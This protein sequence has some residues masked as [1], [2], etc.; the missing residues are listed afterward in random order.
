MKFIHQ[1]YNSKISE[2]FLDN[3]I[4]MI[5][6]LSNVAHI[7]GLLKSTLLKIVNPKHLSI[8]F[9]LFAVT[10]GTSKFNM[11]KLL[12]N[13]VKLDLPGELFGQALSQEDSV[14]SKLASNINGNKMAT[15]FLDEAVKAHSRE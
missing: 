12:R 4:S 8:L 2:L 13:L 14:Q 3:Y 10:E 5:Y 15:Y 1:L 9:K 7:D 11:L 6:I